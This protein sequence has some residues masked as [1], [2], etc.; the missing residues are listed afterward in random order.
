VAETTRQIFCTPLTGAGELAVE[1]SAKPA[2]RANHGQ[3]QHRVAA[4]IEHRS[5]D[6]VDHGLATVEGFQ[7]LPCKSRPP[8]LIETCASS[9]ELSKLV[10]A[11]KLHV[12]GGSRVDTRQPPTLARYSE[13]HMRWSA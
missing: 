6:C 3:C 11:P 5:A 8:N 7:I 1:I 4:R 13:D 10:I 9:T 12:A 2:R